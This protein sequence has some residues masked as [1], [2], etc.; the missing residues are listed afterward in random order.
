MGA[1]FAVRSLAGRATNAKK[2]STSRSR[3]WAIAN[4][5]LFSSSGH[6]P[7]P[8]KRR[9]EFNDCV[10]HWNGRK[11]HLSWA[12]TED[13]GQIPLR[14]LVRSWFETGRRQV[15][16][17]FDP[18]CD[19]LRTT[20]EPDSVMEFGFNRKDYQNCSVLYCVRQL[21]TMI[22][23]RIWTVLKD[24]CWFRFPLD[25]DLLFVC[26]LPRDAAMLARSWES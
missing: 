3:N 21:C 14:Y 23:T 13:K 20:F 6:S 26:F 15:R 9:R 19:Q 11:Q 4:R 25:L 24:E 12:M 22:H 8:H 17:S 10:E 16:T 18:V 5:L 2:S 1:Y 7:R